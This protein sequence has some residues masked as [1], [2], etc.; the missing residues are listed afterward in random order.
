MFGSDEDDGKPLV[1]KGTTRALFLKSAQLQ[2]WSV[3]AKV[4]G[5]GPE[6]LPGQLLWRK[7]HQHCIHFCSCRG[8]LKLNP[9]GSVHTILEI[10]VDLR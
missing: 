10:T 7:L 4:A 2:L 1:M 3:P 5:Q 6:K 9:A 8:K